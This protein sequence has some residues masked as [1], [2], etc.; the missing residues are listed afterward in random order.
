LRRELPL[1][2]KPDQGYQEAQDQNADYQ[3]LPIHL[4]SLLRKF[5]ELRAI[6]NSAPNAANN[7]PPRAVATDDIQRVGGRVHALVMAQRGVVA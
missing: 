4:K 2:D 5:D 7:P 3:R 1:R 6:Y